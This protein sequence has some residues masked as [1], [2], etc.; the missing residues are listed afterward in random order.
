LNRRSTGPSQI[1]E[2]EDFP[3][4]DL[5]KDNHEDKP[6]HDDDMAN[7]FTSI[8]DEDNGTQGHDIIDITFQIF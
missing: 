2:F 3:C 7:A 1:Y 6:L 4:Y 8:F 5:E